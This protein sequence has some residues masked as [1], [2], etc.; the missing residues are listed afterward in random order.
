[1]IYNMLTLCIQLLLIG[2]FVGIVAYFFFPNG[3]SQFFLVELVLSTL[4]AF[5]GTIFEIMIRSIWSLPLGYYQIYQFLVPLLV[6]A[7][8][9]FLYRLANSEK[10]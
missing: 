1:M 4:G 2:F 10:E 8:L 7:F 9:V 6:S 3:R 5:L